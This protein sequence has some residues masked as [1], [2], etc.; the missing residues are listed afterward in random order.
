MFASGRRFAGYTLLRPLG[1][2]EQ[3][4]IWIAHDD[5]NHEV[6]ISVFEG[7]PSDA[8]RE[9]LTAAK[10]LD[11]PN[12]LRVQDGG[13]EAGVFYVV[14]DASDGVD[15]DQAFGALRVDER[16]LSESTA[17]YVI[18]RV[19][20]A[21]GSAHQAGVSHGR[22]R[23]SKIFV[24]ADGVIQLS[25]FVSDA[26]P[27][28]PSEDIRAL[29]TLLA[30]LLTRTALDPGQTPDLSDVRDSLR[31]VIEACFQGQYADGTALVD[32]LQEVVV[33]P[34]DEAELESLAR[35]PGRRSSGVP[36]EVGEPLNTQAAVASTKAVDTD[37]DADRPSSP[38]RRFQL[39]S[40]LGEGGMGEVYL[41]R[42][43]ELGEVVAL[44]LMARRVADNEQL[45]QRMRREVRLAR[46]IA[47]DRVCR[48]YDLVELPDGERGISM[49]YV[50][51][52]TL[53][54]MMSEGVP[55]D[56]DRFCRWGADIAEG[57]AAA[58]DLEIVH[59]DL[60]PDNVMIDE[61][62]RAIIL[63]FGIATSNASEES[64]S[65]ITKQGM[66]LGTLPYMSP[67]QLSARELDH[68]TDL[69]ALGLILA[70]LVT[71][72]V[73]FNG[74]DYHELLERRVIHPE[75]YALELK[76]PGAPARLV[77]IVNTLIVADP[78]LRLDNAR[79][80]AARLRSHAE[81]EEDH[82]DPDRDTERTEPRDV[83]PS[84]APSV[85]PP[86]PTKKSSGVSNIVI[87][88]LGL[89]LLGLGLVVFGRVLDS[90]SQKTKTHAAPPKVI[91]P[92]DAGQ[93]I[94]TLQPEPDPPTKTKPK[95]KPRGLPPVEDM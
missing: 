95:P 49:Q 2:G 72:E 41:A 57:L 52:R 12:I 90:K 61:D 42:D 7:G 58:H 10:Q 80:V 25:G 9:R 86:A 38:P 93:P 23:A 31:E 51:G 13:E 87:A 84:V 6:A 37:V 77:E 71:A 83:Q 14:S 3:T 63:D 40:R 85:P 56:Y 15:L 45:M 44:K 19:A 78:D 74:A 32:A 60:K 1:D 69:Y 50:E 94:E 73:P 30:E 4:N 8:L 11:H 18:E 29:G 75:A 21:L 82:P 59:R 43:T 62:D 92:V 79:N 36:W 91:Q 81:P 24:A 39:M 47:S 55:T 88:G 67:E 5:D 20:A 34:V 27:S 33:P 70:E 46:K 76:D 66:I 89:L 54:Q 26:P 16:W 17:V 64:D 68:R 22:L 53:S 35:L 28:E 65:K 48:L